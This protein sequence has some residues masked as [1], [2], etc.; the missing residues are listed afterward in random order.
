MRA[1]VILLGRLGGDPEL[2]ITIAGTAVCN[3]SIAIDKEGE[4]DAPPDW[5]KVTC[6]EKTAEFCANNL[7]KGCRVL[8]EGRP[9]L[10]EWE[11]KDGTPYA[12]LAVVARSVQAIDWASDT[13]QE[14]KPGRKQAAKAPATKAPRAD[15]KS[16]YNRMAARTGGR[17][18]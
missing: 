6:W 14:E 1:T 7:A 12:K 8:V 13:G 16:E 11:G 9:G 2:R 4:K 18:G 15:G 3:F 17:S 5:W 10:E